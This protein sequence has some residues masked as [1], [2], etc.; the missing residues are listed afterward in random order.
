MCNEGGRGLKDK[1]GCIHSM[2]LNCAGGTHKELGVGG[3]ILEEG[4]FIPRPEVEQEISQQ[5]REWEKHEHER[6]GLPWGPEEGCP[7]WKLRMRRVGLS[8]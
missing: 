4:T 1:V 6:M 7:L 8:A 5:G 3:G 2:A